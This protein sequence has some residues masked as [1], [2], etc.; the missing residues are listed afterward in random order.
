MSEEKSKFP[1]VAAGAFV[2]S[3]GIPGL[4][5]EVKDVGEK[6]GGI[7]GERGSQIGKWIDDKT[8]DVKLHIGL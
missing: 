6:I 1:A 7:F 4:K 8:K 5:V 2:V 3:I